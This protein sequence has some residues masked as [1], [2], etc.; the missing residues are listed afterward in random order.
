MA[1]IINGNLVFMDSM[2]FMNSS[3]DALAKNLSCNDFKY[4]SQEFSN[5]LLELVKQKE[6][7]PYEYMNS[8]KKIFED[9]LPD[10]YNFFNYLKS[11][12]MSWKDYLHAIDVWIMFKMKTMDDYHDFY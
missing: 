9:K 7:Y 10:R 6:V 3:L 8:F 12:Y 1:F 5:K 2:Q 11:E 4:L